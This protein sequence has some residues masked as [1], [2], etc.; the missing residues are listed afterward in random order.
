MDV[1]VTV[2]SMGYCIGTIRGHRIGRCGEHFVSLRRHLGELFDEN[3]DLS[4]FFLGVR[5]SVG[6]HPSHLDA[7]R[8]DPVDLLWLPLGRFL[9]Q[10]APEITGPQ[11]TRLPGYRFAPG[12]GLFVG[13]HTEHEPQ[14]DNSHHST[15]VERHPKSGLAPPYVAE[16]VGGGVHQDVL[17]HG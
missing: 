6:G 2:V 1:V 4:Q 9:A 16:G 10:N 7:M 13:I 8:Q 11:T 3:D 15:H 12:A 17:H 5:R 14:P